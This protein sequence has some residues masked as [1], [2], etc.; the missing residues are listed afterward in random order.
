[1]ADAQEQL[2][3]SSYPDLMLEM[4]MIRMATLA[5]VLDA[6]ELMRAIGAAGGGSGNSS[7]GDD[8]GSRQPA[9]S[10]PPEVQASSTRR[11]RSSAE[12]SAPE[13]SAAMTVV[14]LS[15]PGEANF[16][17]VRRIRFEGDVK[18]DAPRRVPPLIVSPAEPPQASSGGGELPDLREFIRSRRAALAGFMEQ[19]ASLQI[20]GD[21]LTVTPRSDIYVR[22]LTDNRN[23]I[24]ELASELYG[25]RIKVEMAGA[26]AT[27]T[28]ISDRLESPGGAA[29]DSSPVKPTPI[30]A[31]GVKVCSDG[32]AD[33]G[34]SVPSAS[35]GSL[36]RQNQTDARQKLYADP[37][38]QRIFEEFEA[39]LVELKTISI[40]SD[41]STLSISKK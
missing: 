29:A 38:V 4:T 2:A 41:A 16:A 5:P 25:R 31:P 30:D 14:P 37:L 24:G 3:R 36:A 26:G 20:D 15:T 6:D 12:E 32:A 22:Y 23:V 1:M 39:R 13:A 28:A 21:L 8:T 17:P 27:V 7:P 19:G 9:T 10:R 40:R 34:A 18:A 11:V 35:A 33:G